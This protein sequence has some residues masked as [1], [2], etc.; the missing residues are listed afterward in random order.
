MAQ[1]WEE[2]VRPDDWYKAS[3]NHEHPAGEYCGL[4]GICEQLQKDFDRKTPNNIITSHDQ[5]RTTMMRT[6]RNRRREG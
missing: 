3:I 1:V 2:F 5:K 4:H 6:S